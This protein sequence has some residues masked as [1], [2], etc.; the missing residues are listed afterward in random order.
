MSLRPYIRATVAELEELFAARQTDTDTLN[1]L[2]TELQ[3]RNVPRA[4]ALLVRVRNALAGGR[5]LIPTAQPELFTAPL[6]SP[7]P[8]PAAVILPKPVPKP[9]ETIV[10]LPA[11]TLEEA[12]KLLRVSAGS[13]WDEVEQARARLVQRSHPDALEGLS[14]EKRTA[15]VL[16]ARRANSAYAA[17]AQERTLHSNSA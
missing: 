10:E 14:A 5:P 15:A 12:Y 17:L 3:F 11:V 7:E 13:P 9:V 4:T 6:A 16:D 8:E 2:K 1:A